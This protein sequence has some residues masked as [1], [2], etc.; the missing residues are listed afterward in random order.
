LA[1]V[2]ITPLL[3]SVEFGSLALI[4]GFVSTVI[5]SA[6]LQEGSKTILPDFSGEFLNSLVVDFF[7]Q[8]DFALTFL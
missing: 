8:F 7:G 4:A 5:N 2:G 1:V 6:E 3:L